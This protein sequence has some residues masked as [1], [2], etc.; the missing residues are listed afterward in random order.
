MK[1]VSKLISIKNFVEVQTPTMD[2]GDVICAWTE[3]G[4]AVHR[5]SVPVY[6]V[7]YGKASERLDDAF[8]CISESRSYVEGII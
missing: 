6:V 1:Q 5:F 4:P 2:C 7:S 3:H 8:K